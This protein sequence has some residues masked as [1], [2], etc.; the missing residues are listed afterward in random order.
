LVH[1]DNPLRSACGLHLVLLLAQAAGAHGMISGQMRDIVA[2]ACT[3]DHAQTRMMQQQKTGAL[4]R[5]CFLAP[6]HVARLDEESLHNW[7]V[8]GDYF[9][10]IFQLQDDLLDISGNAKILGKK[11]GKDLAQNKATLPA[12]LGEE[13][14]RAH[15]Y[16]LYQQ[17]SDILDILAAHHKM[18]S[19]FDTLHKILLYCVERNK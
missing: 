18:G 15:L 14:A 19:G 4:L 16:D 12:L 13:K 5:F 8:F 3:F 1:P 11:V 7:G 10:Q 17:A 2:E 9:G 6:A